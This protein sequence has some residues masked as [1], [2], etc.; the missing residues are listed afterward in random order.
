MK[1]QIGRMMGSTSKSHRSRANRLRN[2]R[3]ESLE[4]RQLLAAD[5]GVEHNFLI[6][7]D[8]NQDFI[9]SPIDALLIINK[10]NRGNSEGEQNLSSAKVDVNADGILSAVDVLRVI[11]RLNAEGEGSMPLMRYSYQ[12]VDPLTSAAIS[13]VSVGSDFQLKVF[14]QDLRPLLSS[15]VAN[16]D[17]VDPTVSA[18]T[19]PNSPG[20]S[21]IAGS[22]KLTFDSSTVFNVGDDIQIG[23]FTTEIISFVF[24][25][26]D[27]DPNTQ[28][29]VR[30]NTANLRAALPQTVTAGTTVNVTI[31]SPAAWGVFSAAQDLGI[32]NLPLVD[33][34]EGAF[35]SEGILWA[36]IFANNRL[37][38]EGANVVDEYFNELTAFKNQVPPFN[39][40]NPTNPELL[41]S[42]NF[43]AVSQ[44]TVTFN[45]NAA[46][47]S[48]REN[49][50]FRNTTAL[51]ADMVDFGAPFSLTITADPTAPVANDDSLS[52]L[53]DNSIVLGENVTGNDTVTSPRTISIT[54]VTA[55]SGVTQ[56]TIN[57]TTYTPP[58]NFFGTDRVTYFVT[59]STGLASGLATVTI[60]VN[61]VN[62]APNAFNDSLSVDEGSVDNVLDVLANN[63]FGADNAGPAN[64]TSDSITI[65]RVGGAAGGT[66]FTTANGG[67]VSIAAG[68]RTLLYSPEASFV[69][70]DT[71]TYTITDTGGLTAT[72]TVTVDVAPA[73]LPR[74]RRDT[75]SGAENTSVAVSVLDND[76]ANAG[77]TFVLK[78]F[79]AGA[80][81]TV[82]RQSSDVTSAGFNIL[83]YTPSDA[84]FYGTDTF[85]YVI[86]DS[87]LVG[88]DST[89]TVAITITD[90]NDSPILA[91]DSAVTSED[92]A[93]AIAISILLSNDSPGAGETTNTP[94]QTLTL[95]SVSPLTAGGGSVAIVGS[96]VVYTP[97]DD[98]NGQFL[99]SYTAEDNGSPVLEGTATVT[100]SV[101]AVNDSPLANGDFVNG[102]EDTLLVIP[103]GNTS[104][105]DGNV[106]FNDSPGGGADEAGQ[107]LTVTGVSSPSARGGV[108]SLVGSNIN[109]T[110][111]SNFNGTDTFTYSISDGQGGTATGTVTV[112]VAAVND[113]PIAVADSATGFKDIPL[114]IQVSALLGNDSPGGGTDEA[115]QTLS[116]AAVTATA[117]TNGQVVLNT[118]GTITYVPNTGFTGSASFEY[119]LRDSG[120]ATSQ[121]TVNVTVQEFVPS[122][123]SGIV[124][125]DSDVDHAID[126]IERKMG[127]IRVTLTGT[128][129]QGQAIVPQHQIT[130]ADGSYS[131]DGLGPGTYTL[132]YSLP[133]FLRSAASTAHRN[134]LIDNPAGLNVTGQNF[135]VSGGID[136]TNVEQPATYQQVINQFSSSR[137]PIT[138]PSQV[139]TDPQNVIGAL[140]AIEGDNTAM[141]YAL[142]NGLPG[143]E[144]GEVQIAELVLAGSGADLRAYLTVVDSNHVTTT[145]TLSAAN[146]EFFVIY[147]RDGNALVGIQRIMPSSAFQ[148][149]NTAT[150]PFNASRY[151]DSVDEVFAQEGWTN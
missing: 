122:S 106:L 105:V 128:S 2:L 100:V 31:P 63:G 21:N 36:D 51:P 65:T 112:N 50:L 89:G 107:T 110:P 115:G 143:P 114:V 64:E 24:F 151:L 81:G 150:P 9:V 44:G 56:G 72:A 34:L 116:I 16:V 84:N 61:S 91:D 76:T 129:A 19:N 82:S 124:Y 54:A 74:A 97:A 80:H 102:T 120:G 111:A 60:N 66:T 104:I 113:L 22:R 121:G 83:V 90:V 126:T 127:G 145:R 130:L 148:V 23:G 135:A 17:T 40:T 7:E 39:A 96:D 98:F 149:V 77:A 85:T 33:Y 73:V 140:F 103:A 32:T 95:K 68:A 101:S 59:D 93:V 30:T 70:D 52:V 144:L 108:V 62:D 6:A 146:R 133:T 45:P 11:N 18:G 10:M 1:K 53:E 125:E 132:S 92:T 12:F 4:G 3:L 25:D 46:E 67:T 13:Q 136:L 49:S 134:I 141:W 41:Y 8:V 131:F 142:P 94:V 20:Q 147:D 88:P 42:L 14:V 123:I 27:G 26:P 79:S 87:S 43:K 138:S 48:G 37:G 58:S 139:A 99:F 29:S 78:S 71:F 5:L 35:F 75:G 86:N 55:I 137:H 117:S 47:T 15:T 69:G 109:Y 57:G 28:N 118:N 119:T 38:S